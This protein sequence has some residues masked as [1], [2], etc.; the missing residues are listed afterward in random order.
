MY[1]CMCVYIYI[2]IYI[3]IYYT[4]HDRACTP[5]KK[6][7]FPSWQTVSRY[8]YCFFFSSNWC[9]SNNIGMCGEQLTD[10]ANW[11][12]P[13]GDIWRQTFCWTL[14]QVMA[15]LMLGAKP[16]PA[17]MLNYRQLDAQGYIWVQFYLNLKS[18]H[19]RKCIRR[20]RLQSAIFLVLNVSKKQKTSLN[21][22]RNIIWIHIKFQF[23][24]DTHIC[25]SITKSGKWI[26]I[27]MN[28]RG[29][30]Q[31]CKPSLYMQ[32]HNI[33]VSICVRFRT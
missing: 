27:P 21:S 3:Y 25:T 30:G 12:G 14:V 16:L 26:K 28:L 33:F 18:F 24:I 11:L 8:V 29:C 5:F 23:F 17:Q 10:K 4:Q 6:K 31:T 1:E 9:L 19:S 13:S 32:M 7:L 20:C 15:C 2:Y 22:G